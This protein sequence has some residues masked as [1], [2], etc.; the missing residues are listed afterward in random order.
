M[1][2]WP[3][4]GASVAGGPRPEARWAAC[5]GARAPCRGRRRCWASARG[6]W[7][8]GRCSETVPWPTA[9]QPRLARAGPGLPGHRPGAGGLLGLGPPP[10]GVV[11]ALSP[12]QAVAAHCCRLRPR[13]R[14]ATGR[15]RP[16]NGAP[17]AQASGC[18]LAACPGPLGPATARKKQVYMFVVWFGLVGSQPAFGWLRFGSYGCEPRLPIMTA[19]IACD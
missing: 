4:A 1:T 6:A 7:A 12:P 3:E 16:S 15:G 10:V 2:P 8:S 17:R 13:A 14:A 5:R 9:D 11:P 18:L 19:A